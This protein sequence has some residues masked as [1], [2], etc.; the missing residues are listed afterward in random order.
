VLGCAGGDPPALF[1]DADGDDVVFCRVDGAEDRGC[2]VEG[3]LVLAG[4]AAEED[5]D[6]EFLGRLLFGLFLRF[7]R[8]G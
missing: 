6:A 7:F 8:H 3:D 5:A 4:A 1:G 2:G